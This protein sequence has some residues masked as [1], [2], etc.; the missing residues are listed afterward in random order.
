MR[1][2]ILECSV[3]DWFMT[4]AWDNHVVHRTE[5]GVPIFS[6]DLDKNESEMLYADGR[7]N[8]SYLI[9]ESIHQRI[10]L[11]AKMSG[12]IDKYFP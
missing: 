12:D 8:L 3:P 5:A 10:V 4:D 11:D 1:K 7:V 2:V 6:V 9:A